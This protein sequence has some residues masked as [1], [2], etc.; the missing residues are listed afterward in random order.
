MRWMLPS[1]Y[2]GLVSVRTKNLL[3]SQADTRTQGEQGSEL[4]FEHLF[5]VLCQHQLYHSFL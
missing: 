5:N 3:N 4:V 1:F 2:G